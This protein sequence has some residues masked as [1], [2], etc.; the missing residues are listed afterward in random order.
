MSNK[1]IITENSNE[2]KLN[3]K[4]VL[5]YHSAKRIGYR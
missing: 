3:T 1:L 5:W 4:W 2:L